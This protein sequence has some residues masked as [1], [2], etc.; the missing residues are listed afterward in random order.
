[1]FLKRYWN[2]LIDLSSAIG[3]IVGIV[4]SIVLIGWLILYP[5][6]LFEVYKNPFLF[7]IYIIYIL[8]ASF[9][10]TIVQKYKEKKAKQRS[11]MI[12]GE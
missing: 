6:H 3:F 1:M 12:R 9:C 11:K 4:A 7:L 10:T 8:T 5:L 2:N